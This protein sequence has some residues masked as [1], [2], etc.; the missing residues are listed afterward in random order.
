MKETI[1]IM[2]CGWLGLPLAKAFIDLGYTVKGTTTSKE[3]LETLK[4]DGII[5]FQI[6][7]SATSIEGE[8]KAFLVALDILII[9]VPPRLR[10]I[11]TESFVAKMELLY[12]EVKKS[13]LA[14]I[15]FVS[16]TAVYGK[17][18]GLVTEDT[19][20]KPSTAS[21]EQLLQSENLFKNDPVFQTTIVRF[22]GLIG[23][24]RNPITMLVKKNQLTNGGDPINLI[25]LEDCISILTTIVTERYWGELFNAVYPDH[26]TKMHHYTREAKK[27]GLA[28]PNYIESQAT[29]GK[30]IAS[31]R[32]TQ[33]KNYSFRKPVSID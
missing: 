26:P 27:R 28:M 6:G 9:N 29:N 1:G 24:D 13:K 5:P 19:I 31:E 16:S 10:G 21:G 30:I 2:G 7:L 12:E 20:P 18:E 14:K 15:I 22:G 23:P 17:I 25:H 8:I 11:N 32:L 3:K 4:G 33:G